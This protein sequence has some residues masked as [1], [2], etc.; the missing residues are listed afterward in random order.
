MGEVGL[1]QI[2]ALAAEEPQSWGVAGQSEGEGGPPRRTAGQAMGPGW[3]HRDLIGNG[4]R[5]Q[6]PGAVYYDA[7]IGLLDHR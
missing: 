6:Q 3:I 4:Q 1:T 5:G 2:E 7:R